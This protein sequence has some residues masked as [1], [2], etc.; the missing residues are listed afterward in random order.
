MSSCCGGCGGQDKE[1]KKGE[2]ED[3]TEKKDKPKGPSDDKKS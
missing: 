2:I 3:K 1:P